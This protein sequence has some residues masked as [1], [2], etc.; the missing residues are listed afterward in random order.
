MT[1]KEPGTWIEQR[2]AE[3]EVDIAAWKAEMQKR[4]AAGGE[5][6]DPQ[7]LARIERWEAECKGL[8]SLGEGRQKE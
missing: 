6:E 8:K 5:P 7:R 1:Q 3:L 2:I 4:Q